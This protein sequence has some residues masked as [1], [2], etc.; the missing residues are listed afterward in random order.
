VDAPRIAVILIMGFMAYSLRALPHVFSAA[1]S[2]PESW[3]RLLRN[4]SY[5][6][7]CSIIAVTL[8]MSGARFET[9]PAPFRALALIVTVVVARQ[10]QS[11]VTGMLTG[12]LV[13]SLLSW[14]L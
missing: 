2:F 13:V 11:A 6:L 12:T 4:I 5:A 3:E 8:F 14:L 10:T 7:I 9:D 1:R